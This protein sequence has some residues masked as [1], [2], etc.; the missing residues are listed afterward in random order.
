MGG[1]FHGSMH[2]FIIFKEYATFL[3][4]SVGVG[5]CI[6]FFVMIDLYHNKAMIIYLYISIMWW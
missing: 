2:V 4:T 5:Y 1:N 3:P 6:N